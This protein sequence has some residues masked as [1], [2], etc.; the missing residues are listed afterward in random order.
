VVAKVARI[1]PSAQAGSRSVLAY[2]TVVDAE[3]LR[4]GLFAQGTLGTAQTS[5]LAVP[6]SAIRTDKPAPYV[7]VVENNQVAHKTVETGAR[8]DAGKEVMVAVK[9]VNPGTLVIKGNVGSLREGTP[10]KFTKPPSP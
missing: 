5:G 8:G 7:Q 6:L 1:N 3:G 10:V 9:G 2:L 4:Q